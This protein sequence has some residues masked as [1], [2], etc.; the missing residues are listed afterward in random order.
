MEK[1][2]VEKIME[3]IRED[4]RIKGYT[5][6]MLSFNDVIVEPQI[7]V[8]TGFAVSYTHLTLPTIYS[9]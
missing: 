7:S 8:N 5:N 9:V 2:D 1:I 3:E 4:I 6:D